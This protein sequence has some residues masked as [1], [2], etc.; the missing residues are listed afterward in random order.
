LIFVIVLYSEMPKKTATKRTKK[1]TTKKCCNV[2]FHGLH[3]WKTHVFEHLGWMVLMH[4]KGNNPCKIKAYKKSL[5][6]LKGSL[7]NALAEVQETDRKRDIKIM[8]EDVNILI[9][10]VNKDFK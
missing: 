3:K 1:N 8:W 2:T 4:K 5:E 6:N 10:H 9:D 7:E